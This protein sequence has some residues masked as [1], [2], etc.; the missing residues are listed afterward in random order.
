MVGAPKPL[1]AA[2]AAP[3]GDGFVAAPKP[4]APVEL[5]KAG[6]AAVLL[7]VELPKAGAATAPNPVVPEGA[8]VCWLLPNVKAPAA[9]P[10]PEAVVVAAPNAEAGVEPNAGTVLDDA[11]DAP[12]PL[13]AAPKGVEATVVVVAEDP[14][15][16]PGVP[17]NP[18]GIE[19]PAAEVPPKAVRLDVA[20]DPNIVA[21]VVV[22]ATAVEAAAAPKVNGFDCAC[23]EL[24]KEPE[25][26]NPLGLL[27]PKP[28]PL[29]PVVCFSP[30]PVPAPKVEPLPN[31]GAGFWAEEG[32]KLDAD[33]GP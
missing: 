32:C 1:E 29:G 19:V 16:V 17:P 14:K 20:P 12:N 28:P 3:N 10:K 27:A 22:A 18:D 26:L 25:K 8:L 11:E 6:G 30:P 31:T 13:D 9:L 7:N 5:P 33:E 15:P 21:L 23:P 2:V 24:L 4:L